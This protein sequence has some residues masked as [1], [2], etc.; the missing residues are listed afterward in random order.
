MNRPHKSGH[1]RNVSGHGGDFRSGLILFIGLVF[2]L[3]SILCVQTCLAAE[4]QFFRIGTGGQTGV[5][6]PIGKAI[7]MG[8]TGQQASVSD[9]QSGQEGIP[10][11]IGIAQNSAGSVENARGVITGDIEAGLVQADVAARIFT[12]DESYGAGKTGRMLRA[13]AGLYP[14]KLQIVTRTDA[15]ITKISD[16]RGKRVSIDEPGSGTLSVMRIVMGVH[17]LSEKDF[18][19]VYLKPVFTHD[20]LRN[21]QIDGFVIMAGTPADAVSQISDIGIS[22]VPV[23]PEK[24]AVINRQ[25]PYLVPGTIGAGIYSNNPETPT[26]QVHA[27]LVVNE[28]MDSDLVYQVTACLWRP[29]TLNLLKDHPQGSSIFLENALTGVSIPIHPGARRFYREQGIIS[30]ESMQP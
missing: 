14:E 18:F 28:S 27:L 7:A 17:N 16:I 5:Y 2:F 12:E 11:Y 19:P 4:K 24:A 29:H 22:L 30:K 21:G 20:K 15:G 6:Y 10:G 3:M 1:H 23:A 8:I 26:I 13:V 9:R 25:Y